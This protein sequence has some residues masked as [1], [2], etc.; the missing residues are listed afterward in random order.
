LHANKLH[1]VSN[2]YETQL[3]HDRLFLSVTVHV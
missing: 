2:I 3:S 1:T